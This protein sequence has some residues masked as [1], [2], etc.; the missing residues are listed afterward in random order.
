MADQSQNA[1]SKSRQVSARA[2][3]VGDNGPLVNEKLVAVLFESDLIAR[4]Q[5]H[6]LYRLINLCV[7]VCVCLCVCERVNVCV[8]VCV[9]ERV[10]DSEQNRSNYV[11]GCT[12][13]FVPDLV[14]NPKDS[15][16]LS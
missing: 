2:L 1:P 10:C 14:G 15:D 7:C 16:S 8:N 9:C 11:L 3:P 5:L 6:V 12:G 4:K 13:R